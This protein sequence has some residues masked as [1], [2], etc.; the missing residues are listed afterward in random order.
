MSFQIF[1]EQPAGCKYILVAGIFSIWLAADI[2]CNVRSIESAPWQVYGVHGNTEPD[3]Y[4]LPGY[5][6]ALVFLY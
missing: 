5:E 6:V 4:E 3:N 2:E 1:I